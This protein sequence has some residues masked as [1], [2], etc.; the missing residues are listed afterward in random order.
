M[1]RAELFSKIAEGEEDVMSHGSCSGNRVHPN[2][3][4]QSAAR[5]SSTG[6]TSMPSAMRRRDQQ[7]RV[8]AEALPDS[9]STVGMH[10]WVKTASYMR[11]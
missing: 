2:S 1:A 11:F 4:P 8:A 9:M 7:T 6:H 3:P 5:N 10:D